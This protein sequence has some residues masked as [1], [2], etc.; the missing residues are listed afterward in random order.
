MMSEL[1]YICSVVSAGRSHRSQVQGK[2]ETRLSLRR[3][4][5]YKFKDT[6][7]ECPLIGA[8]LSIPGIHVLNKDDKINVHTLYCTFF[9]T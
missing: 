8:L 2:V 6:I 1:E 3:A 9:Q 7:R 4:K 5:L